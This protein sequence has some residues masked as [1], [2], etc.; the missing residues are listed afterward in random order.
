MFLEGAHRAGRPR[1]RA[2]LPATIGAIG[3]SRRMWTIDQRKMGE[4][5]DRVVS[6]EITGRG[7]IGDLY[8]AA[9][10]AHGDAL[11][12]DAAAR[13]LARVRKG[14]VVFFATGLPTYPWLSGERDGPAG[15]ATLA[16]ALVVAVGA[17]SVVV[18][19]PVN[20]DI[21]RAAL[22]GAGL[23]VR[24]LEDVAR[25]PTTA[26]VLPFPLGW[27]QA[28]GRARELL[29]GLESAAL[30]AIERPGPTSGGTTIHRAAGASRTTAARSTRCST[31]RAAGAR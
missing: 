10:A 18:T 16:R 9:R 30:I 23:D 6:I 20:V 28:R 15:A 21:C 26:A 1:G 22:G 27:E 13:L 25:L 5:I 11:C 7:V 17:R 8:A 2:T 4:A 31:W 19:D 12:L 29:D 14:D 24:P 3:D